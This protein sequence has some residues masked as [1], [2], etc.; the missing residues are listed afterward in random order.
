MLT[1]HRLSCSYLSRLCC[2]DEMRAPRKPLR[3]EG[4]GCQCGTVSPGICSSAPRCYMKCTEPPLRSGFVGRPPATLEKR[5]P[6]NALSKHLR[7]SWLVRPPR[8]R[9]VI[10][11]LAGSFNQ[12]VEITS[13]PER[14]N[15]CRVVN[16]RGEEDSIVGVLAH[17]FQFS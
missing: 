17:N 15:D 1:L 16:G 11:Q 3:N 2:I 4:D 8:P 14:Q 10:E 9:L 5:V 12:I 6:I 13:Q 7:R